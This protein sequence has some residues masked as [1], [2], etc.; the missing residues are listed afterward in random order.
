ME[1]GSIPHYCPWNHFMLPPGHL[2]PRLT[3]SHGSGDTESKMQMAWLAP[4]RLNCFCHAK[5]SSEKQQG[6]SSF[7]IG[8]WNKEKVEGLTLFTHHQV[9]EAFER[10]REREREGVRKKE[11]NRKRSSNIHAH[12]SNTSQDWSSHTWTR[13]SM[14]V[15]DRAHT[16]AG[17]AFHTEQESICHR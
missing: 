11:Q 7:M 8:D 10:E 3:S 2:S 6:Q 13:P 1:G 5:L 4:S 15:A 9:W 14:G 17:A 16:Y 12:W